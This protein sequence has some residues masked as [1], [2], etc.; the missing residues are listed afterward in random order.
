MKTILSDSTF[1]ALRNSAEILR[2]ELSGIRP[3]VFALV[4]DANA[5]CGCDLYDKVVGRAVAM[6][7]VY[8]GAASVHAVMMSDTAEEVLKTHGIFYEYLEKT[9]FIKNRDGSGMCPMEKI[10]QECKSPEE[11][12]DKLSAAINNKK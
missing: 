4:E 11:A 6:L 1:V 5:L 2:S 9:P 3:V 8:G 7:A 12:Y 10:S